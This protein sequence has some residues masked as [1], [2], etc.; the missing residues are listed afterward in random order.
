MNY[1][2]VDDPNILT[3][4]TRRKEFYQF[5]KPEEETTKIQ[6]DWVSKYDLNELKEDDVN[7]EPQSYQSM[8]A[9]F[10][11]PYTPYN[12]LLLKWDPGM[13]KTIAACN[14]A[15]QFIKLF[16]R[17]SQM[18]DQQIGSVFIIGFTEE[19]FKRELLSFPKF[20]FV[21][22]D[23]LKQLH[24]LKE[25][26]Q[27]GNKTDADRLQ[28][29]TTK[30]KKRLGSR[31]DN[32]Y[33]RFFGYKA[34]VNRI[35]MLQ[36]FKRNLNDMDEEEIRR[37]LKDGS[38]KWNQPLLDSF[39]NS[40][41]ICDEIHNVYNSL[42]KNNWGVALQ[43]VL[44]HDPSIK[45]LFMS[46]T[47]INNNPTEVIDL[48]N[49]MQPP[50]EKLQ[51]DDFFD[52]KLLKKGA[53]DRLGDVF[54]G[55]VSFIQD[56]DPRHFATMEMVGEQ[57]D[58]IP[59][60]KF[61]RC[62]MS[63][64][65]FKTYEKVYTGVLAQDAQY[66]M[67]IALPNPVEPT[68]GLYRTTEIKR[69]LSFA[70]DDWYK[71]YGF[72]MQDDIIVGPGLYEQNIGE[73]SS[74]YAQLLK[75]IKADLTPK[76]GK[77]LIYHD[78]VH[79]SGVLFIEQLLQHNGFIG[80]DQ[81]DTMQTLCAVC[82]KVKQDHAEMP[83][84]GGAKKG[85]S[86]VAPDNSLAEKMKKLHRDILG[87]EFK[88]DIAP[89]NSR[90]VV[91]GGEPIAFITCVD[92][93][94]N[95]ARIDALVSDPSYRRLGIEEYLLEHYTPNDKVLTASVPADNTGLIEWYLERYFREYDRTDEYVYLSFE[96]RPIEIND[97]NF[98]GA[99]HRTITKDQAVAH[100][101][102]YRVQ[103][104]NSIW[105]D[106]F[107][108][109]SNRNKHDYQHQIDTVMLLIRKPDNTPSCD[110]VPGEEIAG[111]ITVHTTPEFYSIVHMWFDNTDVEFMRVA[112]ETL[113]NPFNPDRDVISVPFSRSDTRPDN[114]D[115]IRDHRVQ[116]GGKS[117]NNGKIRDHSFMPA[118][119]I[120]AHSDM[121][122]G[123]MHKN[124][125]RF[126]SI[127]NTW[128]YHCRIIIGSKIIKESYNF[129]AIRKVKVTAR[130]ANTT[131]LIQILGRSRRKKAHMMLPTEYRNIEV[132]IYTSCLP[133]KDARGRYRLSH[134][135]QKYKEK[136]EDFKI[137]QSIE[138]KL[139][140][141]AID[142]ITARNIVLPGLDRKNPGLGAL[143][144]EPDQ[145][146][147]RYSLKDLNLGT[148]EI[149]HSGDEIRLII[150]IIKRLYIEHS[151][152]YT[153]DDLWEQVQ[154]PPF[155]VEQDTNIFQQSYFVIALSMLVFGTHN[156]QVRPITTDND[157][158]QTYLLDVLHSD[159]D[160]RI[161]QPDGTIGYIQ[162]IDQYYIFV[163]FR[164]GNPDIH[165]ESPFR[166][167]DLK[168][169][170]PIN[171]M[172]YL[173][174][175][176][177]TLNYENQK[178]KF[179]SKYEGVPLEKLATV[180]GKFGVSF[181]QSFVEE[182]IKYVFNL[183]TN[184]AISVKSEMHEFYF[185]ML[186][187]YDLMGLVVWAATAKEFIRDQYKPYMLPVAILKRSSG[188][189]KNEIHSIEMS[190]NRSANP[191]ESLRISKTE[192]TEAL[193]RSILVL[194]DRAKTLKAKKKPIVDIVRADPK[195]LPIGH[196]MANAP[197]FFHPDKD[198]FE[199]PEYVQRTQEYKENDI[200][201]GYY[202]KSGT[203]L[204]VKFK[205][206]SPIHKIQKHKDIRMIEK[207]SICT[208]NSKEYLL[209]IAKKLKIKLPE[210]INVPNL[211]HEIE[212]KLQLNELEERKAKTNI[213]WFFSFWEVQPTEKRLMTSM[214]SS[215]TH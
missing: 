6:E 27:N 55:R 13:G 56:T 84:E 7:L 149:F 23:E 77:I 70:S 33:F 32:G 182:T 126:N 112:L 15:M 155:H 197:R 160:K 66:L 180:V 74:K 117:T 104:L 136:I 141:N 158:T 157:Q 79:V 142:G 113:L 210:K 198:W 135:E 115:V 138:Q 86:V 170:R 57:I 131:T 96:G 192:Y 103:P 168:L 10:L 72:K 39:K 132:K 186:Y 94:S 101:N 184:P 92:E 61:I 175:S 89:C 150:Y 80:I 43:M 164:N 50:A 214:V 125:D 123:Q 65:H 120:V 109:L 18:E 90:A 167:F 46:A 73:W 187:Y 3:D 54:R 116:G 165:V 20:G 172:R 208:S 83:V 185:K 105:A 194:T 2:K 52:G 108:D 110:T 78:V 122:K 16:E 37:S 40:L 203:G 133:T 189:L 199:S 205:I 147:K 4:L 76:G 44:D 153:F 95:V 12:R 190:L 30:L 159:I 36:D 111:Y 154:N 161:M 68:T 130:P 212:A 144:F 146:K 38:L 49:L 129:R 174:E 8:V 97:V 152:C 24:V 156:G 51:K 137:I 67:D 200:I 29:F 201:I 204:R 177:A 28:E 143:W 45:A 140:E 139:H 114:A 106:A 107:I 193:K 128:G 11:S 102:K 19:I 151:L 53:L 124:I 148:F 21:N 191:S 60:L 195:V 58:G 88:G 35:F 173:K 87:Y 1:L 119:Y 63:P 196:F 9:N 166:A 85:W 169:N 162:H 93:D 179:K 75:D 82:G 99:N 183:W 127:D 41:V 206:R 64:F 213:K 134:E 211:C 81:N 188:D 178:L 31:K 215:S 25:Q 100:M 98:G 91:V 176:T 48:G 26:V 207:G 118:R 121:D 145:P 22:R 17:E 163:P 62:P 34:F 181:H 59:Y 5:H 14:I 71:K 171:V 42:E 202:E 69:A 47:P 209:D